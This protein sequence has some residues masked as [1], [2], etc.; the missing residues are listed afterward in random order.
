MFDEYQSGNEQEST[1][2]E[3]TTWWLGRWAHV[4]TIP[5]WFI[6]F[7]AFNDRPRDSY[8][9]VVCAYTVLVLSLALGNA[10]KDLDDVL[11]HPR[12][13]AC[14]AKLMIPHSFALALVVS[15]VYEWL[16]ISHT[17]PAWVTH[18]GRKGSVWYWCGMLPLGGAGYWEGFWMARKLRKH[19]GV[20]ED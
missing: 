7:V 10:F 6:L 15:C 14:I 1:E 12:A 18:E 2:D 3:K 8:V 20:A 17:L 4:L 9:S 13:L 11:G 16:N 5:V 19:C